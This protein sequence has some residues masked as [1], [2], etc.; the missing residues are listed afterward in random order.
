MSSSIVFTLSGVNNSK[1]ALW[2][3]MNV[4]PVSNIFFFLL[5]SV[6]IH[7]ILTIKWVKDLMKLFILAQFCVCVSLTNNQMGLLL[8]K[9]NWN[10]NIFD[11]VCYNISLFM[12]SRRNISYHTSVSKVNHCLY[13]LFVCLFFF[14]QC[15]YIVPCL[16]VIVIFLCFQQ[17]AYV[18]P[19]N[20][21]A[22]ILLL[23]MYG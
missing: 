15:N 14:R 11:V 6:D 23:V 10:L 5:P 2:A 13:F 17:K 22:L 7:R 18:S 20:L 21:P 16:I 19:P 3:E 1:A 8:S 12:E 9:L 4:E